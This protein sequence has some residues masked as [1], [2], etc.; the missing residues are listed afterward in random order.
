MAIG[1]TSMDVWIETP[2][3][4]SLHDHTQIN[5]NELG[6]L[7]ELVDLRSKKRE[8]KLPK[9]DGYVSPSVIIDDFLYQGQLKHGN[10]KNLL[11]DLNI[12]HI[13]NVSDCPL[14]RSI[15]DHFDVLWINMKNVAAVDIGQYFE[16]TNEFLNSCKAKDEK[17]LVHCMMG[18]SRSSTI[19]LAYLL[20]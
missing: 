9:G 11:T 12:R 17:V 20:R 13:L 3:W 8:K 1:S 14:E 7:Q 19:I 15:L 10:N 2:W 16:K 6:Y 5:D 4:E 18:I